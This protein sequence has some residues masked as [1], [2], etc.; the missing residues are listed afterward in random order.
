[1][2]GCRCFDFFDAIFLYSQV[3]SALKRGSFLDENENLTSNSQY[4]G[5]GVRYCV[6]QELFTN[7]NSHT[8]FQLAPK[9]VTLNYL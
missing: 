7:R 3:L 8:G 9:S 2:I 6:S 1:M 5:N 4:H